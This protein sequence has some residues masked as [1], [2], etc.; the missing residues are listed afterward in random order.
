MHRGGVGLDIRCDC[1]CCSAALVVGAR[2]GS[3]PVRF[4]CLERG[5]QDGERQRIRESTGTTERERRLAQ[6]GCTERGLPEKAFYGPVIAF[7]REHLAKRDSQLAVHELS[8]GEPLRDG[9]NI[10]A[11]PRTIEGELHIVMVG[12]PF[13]APGER[14]AEGT[15]CLHVLRRGTSATVVVKLASQMI[16]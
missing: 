10:I 11:T 8:A 12:P 4:R 13:Y 5:R 15:Y 3:T 2:A 6:F 14:W 1:C 9:V 16:R 7:A